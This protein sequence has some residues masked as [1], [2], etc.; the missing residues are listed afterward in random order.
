MT[1]ADTARLIAVI[2]TAYKNPDKF[3]NKEAVEDTVNLWADIFADDDE[4]IVV[5]AVKKHI[6]TSKW[7]PA[8]SEIR[9]LIVE[10]QCPDLIAP[11]E[12]WASVAQYIDTASEF[13]GWEHP[14][15]L[16][17]PQIVRAVNA[18]GYKNLRN[19]RKRKNDLNGN[20]SGLDRVAFMQVYEP[21]YERERI[22]AMTPPHLRQIIQTTQENLSGENRAL[23][24]N[25]AAYLTQKKDEKQ[26]AY[27]C[28]NAEG[29]GLLE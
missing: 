26:W 29:L 10:I 18:I 3:D 16:F 4:R 19:L 14:E 17:P 7:F 13:S 24:K 27:D 8:I 23:L 6:A 28:M 12:A 25:T 11:D 21:E 5:L 1:R 22:N 20:K 2:I 9:E 15:R